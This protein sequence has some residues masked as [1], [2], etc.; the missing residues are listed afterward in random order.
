MTDIIDVKN[1]IKAILLGDAEVSSLVGSKI[2]VGW[3]QRPLNLPCI[4][5]TDTMENG[6]VGMLGGGKDEYTSTVQVDVWSGKSPLERDQ[7]AKAVKAALGKKAN[8]ENMQ[9]SGF[10][11]SSP[12]IRVLDEL[13]VKPII[14]RKSMSFTVLYFTDNYA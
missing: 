2:H 13:D 5:I 10:I 3:L 7:I 11:L 8:F 9:S 4:T 6:Q 1:S 12:T 14:Y